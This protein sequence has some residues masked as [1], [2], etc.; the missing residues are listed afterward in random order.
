[1]ILTHENIFVLNTANTTY[2]FHILPSGHPEHLYY[3]PALGNTGE[4]EPEMLAEATKALCEKRAFPAGNMISYS[5]EYPQLTPE[6]LCLEMSSYG[7]GD[8][9]E[10]FVEVI[11]PDGSRTLDFRFVKAEI[12]EQKPEYETLPGS[13]SEDGKVEHLTV[14]LEEKYR[15]LQL[16]L[17]Y[18]VYEENDVICRSSRLIN[19]SEQPVRLERLMS[20]QLD[21]PEG[22]FVM[23]VF[24]G[25]WARE[26]NRVDTPVAGGRVVNSS[27]TGSSSNRANPFVM[28]SRTGTTETAGLCYGMNLIYS[29]NHYES[30]EVNAFGKT[31]FVS[32]INPAGFSFLLAPEE[33]FEAPE[34][35]M[36]CSDQGFRGLSLSMQ[37]FVR[38]HIVR[39]T[40]K[41]RVRPILLNS[42]EAAYFK[43]DEGKLLRMA[44]EA[45][46]VGIELFVM[47]DGWFGKRDSDTCSLGD[48]KVNTD[49]LPGGL[50][51]LAD[52]IR[53]LGMDF[54]IWVEPEMVNTDSDLYRQ[55][56]EWSMEIPGQPHS[57]GRNQRILDF[58]NP[59]VVDYMTEAITEVLNSAEISY[60][61]WD[62]N[63]IM[64]DVYSPYLPAE[65]QSETAHRYMLGVYRMMRTITERFPQILFEGCA[66]GGNRFDLGI[67]S[68]FPQIWASDDTDPIQRA[69]IQEGYSYGYPMSTVSA[70]VSA[71]PN[72]QTLRRTPLDTRYHTAAFGVLGYEC[73]LADMS[74]QELEEIRKQIELYKAWR[75]VYFYGDFYRLRT[76]NIHEW[77]TVSTDRKLAAGMLLQELAV[78]NVQ[79][80]RFHGAGLKPEARYRL[81]N[82]VQRQDIRNFGDLVNTVSPVHVKQGSLP[83]RVLARFVTM[84]G[85]QEEHCVSGSLLMH[86]GV[87][88]AQA[89]SGTGYNEET[90]YFQDFSSRMY[91]LE[92]V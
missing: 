73:N 45:K 58:A 14:T 10:P 52:K 8:I 33:A 50:K 87:R 20:T 18:Y 78:P 68:Y 57:E 47:D 67:L 86:A 89:Y 83:H 49:K 27:F 35:V 29:G 31:R 28:L 56:P 77:M 42:W 65:R 44:K 76:G 69:K 53:Q 66:A 79:S 51:R 46:D 12:T 21:L 48:W 39:G 4:E 71:S 2:M 16:E 30:C 26:M 92:E 61:K 63:R 85:E 15:E 37:H 80:E 74:R 75:E 22:D 60:V 24:R 38:E 34:A 82:I 55:H 59:E 7:K 32:G 1:M 88:L 23:S 40:W 36:S 91:Y 84:P 17:H 43:F 5:P 6:D 41:N 90:R 72:H 25:A 19:H 62:M 54:G 11:A 81:Y 3:G 70:H 64:S 13:Y 9:R